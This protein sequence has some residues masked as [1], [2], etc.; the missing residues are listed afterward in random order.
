MKTPG[1]CTLSAPL[2]R[3]P[4][5]PAML[6]GPVRHGLLPRDATMLGWGDRGPARVAALLARLGRRPLLRLEDG[7]LRSVGLGKAGAPTVAVLVDRT[8]MHFDARRP[9]DI[10]ALI[11]RAGTTPARLERSKALLETIRRERLDKYNLPAASG[12]AP[13]D[14]AILL[15]DQVAGDRSIAGAGADRSTFLAMLAEAIAT[16]GASSIV[17]KTHPD[18]IS[19]FAAGNL[20]EAAS[21]HG[22]RLIDSQLPVDDL[23]G[24]V[25]AIWTVSSTMG[26]EA[27]MR[28]IPVTTFG[29]PFYAGWGLS[30][31]R[32]E[33]S[34]ARLARQRRQA[35]PP[36]L[37]VVAAVF[38][39]YTRYGNPWT[40]ERLEA[41]AALALL[42]Q[43]KK[44]ALAG[45]MFPAPGQA[46]A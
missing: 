13:I 11:N 23:A 29:M 45:R 16:H 5:L 24:R 36:L 20:T 3:M 7:F 17:V 8:G 4:H 18:V 40:G 35:R 25:R 9:S 21:R 39:D 41:E 14:G 33:G 19:G 38:L 42:V 10:E 28:S 34:I 2:A 1:F 12:P 27:L 26:F 22:I 32:A 44:A 15:I 37:D 31:D 46:E 6:G 43:W 30:D